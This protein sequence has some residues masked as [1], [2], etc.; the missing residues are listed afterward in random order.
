MQ[1]ARKIV[2][3]WC[4]LFA[5]TSLAQ[6]MGKVSGAVFSSEGEKLP[7][8]LV[9]IKELSK[10]STANA[11]GLFSIDQ[12]PFGTYTVTASFIGY[13]AI[14]KT[15]TLFAENTE[16][17]I[18]F[19][20]P[21]NT[22]TL[23]EV[24]VTGNASAEKEKQ[25]FALETISLKPIQNQS[26][27]LNKVLDQVAGM[28]VRQD[29]GLGSRVSYTLN[30]LRGKAVRFFLDGVPMDYFGSSFSA[31]TIPVSMIE[32][33]EVYKGVV[34]VE[35]G[36]DALG[37]AVNLV[38]KKQAANAAELSYSYGSFNTHRTALTA[39]YRER[40]TGLSAKLAAFYNYSDN[41]YWVWGKDIYAT[42]LQTY[43]IERGLKVQR[44][45]DRFESRSVKADLG[46]TQKKWAD[47]AF[48]GL[49]YSQMSKD[50]QHGTT[51]EVP[52]G[53][54]RYDQTAIMPY[55]TYLKHNLLLKG[56]DMN[57]FAAYS[58]LKRNLVDTSRNI[59]N[60]YG[61]VEG[62]R[63]L[64]GERSRSLN[65]LTEKAWLS[66]ANVVYHLHPQHKVG[67]NY[68]FNQVTRQDHDPLITQ[69]TEGYY[70]PQLVQKHVL[71]L[72]TQSQFLDGKLGVS[73]FGKYFAN[74]AHIKTSEVDRQ[75]IV[76]YHTVNTSSEA[77]GYGLATSWK[78]TYFLT[79]NASC[80]RA[81][82]LPEADEMLGDGLLVSSTTQLRPEQ[83][84][85]LN[86]GFRL[87]AFE[88]K[89][90][91][92]RLNAN[93]FYRHVTDLIQLRQFPNDLAMYT[94]F[95]KVDMQGADARL[96][97]HY[98]SYFSFGQ[99]VSYLHPLVRN[100]KDELG[101]RNLLANSRLPNTPFLQTYTDARIT[102]PNILLKDTELFFYWGMGYVGGF[103]KDSE[104][105][106]KYNKQSIPAQLVHDAG[107]GYTFPKQ[108][109]T[110]AFD[111]S[112]MTD[113]Q[114]FDNYAIQKPGRAAYVKATFRFI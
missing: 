97:Y 37:G 52:F 50:L 18:K 9:A 17:E 42:N 29:G 73:V 38:T 84:E 104:K 81:N 60:W 46:F 5:S 92:L 98:K 10:G 67:F 68:V 65:T 26:V 55:L 21:E 86:L 71:G 31:N 61:K 100:D 56:L 19:V 57:L 24:A 25:G 28:R 105:V 13:Q 111:L 44:F 43:E 48:V 40:K 87:Q 91:K 41:N 3:V 23:N 80:E 1:K 16:A 51:M 8:A 33:V 15:I 77:W 109:F 32:R 45:H 113:E 14:S 47:Q 6:D 76:R 90:N 102:L 54:A 89:S 79:L 20:L 4:C 39:N 72:S 75:G 64:G 96:Q 106:G 110:L 85:N 82:R 27:E 101:N 95:D 114:V 36:N 2:W 7:H 49:L 22:Q 12:I 107:M 66:R 69:K 30:G 83:S 70:A 62:Q 88:K 35:L 74:A 112:N 58:N 59:Y 34:P 63:T 99:S 78:A 11:D 108:R 93:A 103:F 53:Q 94:N